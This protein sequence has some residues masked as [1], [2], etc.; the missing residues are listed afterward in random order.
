MV[1]GLN[2]EWEMRGSEKAGWRKEE[3]EVRNLEVNLFM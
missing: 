3:F 2:E 1:D